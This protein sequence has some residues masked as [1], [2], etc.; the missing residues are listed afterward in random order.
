MAMRQVTSS[1][2]VAC[3]QIMANKAGAQ[4]NCGECGKDLIDRPAPNWGRCE[5]CEV[6][7]CK[8]C[9]QIFH[10]LNCESKLVNTNN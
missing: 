10:N 5:A 4:S 9:L 1:V 8:N 3:E 2:V 7:F 6:M